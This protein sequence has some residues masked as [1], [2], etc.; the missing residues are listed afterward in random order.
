MTGER[1]HTLT[2]SQQAWLTVRSHLLEH[3]FELALAAAE[4]YPWE[5]RV[6]DT[7]LLADVRWL[8]EQPL[9]LG[10]VELVM[11]PDHHSRATDGDVVDALSE[12]ALPTRPDGTRYP[13]YSAVVAD[14]S[15]PAAFENRPTYRLLDA[16]L[17]VTAG[18]MA[19]GRGRYF[20]GVDIG[21]ACAHEYAA[22]VLMGG[23]KPLREA[24]GAP[25]DLSR[26]PANLAISALTL[27][28]DQGTGDASFLMHRRDATRVGHAGGLYQVLPVGI[29]QPSGSAEWNERNDFDLWRNLTREFAEELLGAPEDYDS[30]RAPIDYEAWPFAKRLLAARDSG[31]IRV[32]VAGL[33]CDP[34]TFATD[35]L[36]VVTI[37]ARTFDELF[38]DLVASNSEGELV[39]PARQGVKFTRT[40][41]SRFARRERT[42]AAGAALLELAWR[43]RHELLP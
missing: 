16:D 25:W 39:A 40:N 33:G 13:S 15:P 36:V 26:R 5:R 4:G 28:V 29:F 23:P 42:Q 31:A 41:V 18:R 43:R 37:E 27:R 8:P 21:E 11:S 22:S 12:V 9:E 20:D 34:L 7:A 32:H 38:S 19:F 2:D 10:T 1:S 17:G 6:S 24:I 35:L 14:L 3:R 30:E